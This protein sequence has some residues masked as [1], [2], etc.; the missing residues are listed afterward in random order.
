MLKQITSLKKNDDS[1][2]VDFN[3][4]D[5][6]EA[7]TNTATILIQDDI[8]K[9]EYFCNNDLLNGKTTVYITNKDNL[10]KCKITI[11]AKGKMTI[12]TTDELSIHTSNKVKI[13]T[14]ET[15]ISS[16]G[17]ITMY[18]PTT[19][20]GTLHVTDATTIDADASIGTISFLG[21]FHTGNVGAPT[22]PPIG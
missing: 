14:N 1:R 3:Y 20:N 21:H 16:D 22:S 18:G 5:K 10:G 19:I 9:N 11:D 8:V 2:I 15:S 12:E 13:E 6:I 4:I 17:G 7:K